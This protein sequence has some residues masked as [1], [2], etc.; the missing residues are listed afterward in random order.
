MDVVW[1]HD[2]HNQL[3]KPK[4]K[5]SSTLT[6]TPMLECGTRIK[7]VELAAI[8]QIW[9]LTPIGTDKSLTTT[10]QHKHGTHSSEN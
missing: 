6:L 1:A 9:H 8:G 2:S 3:W 10:G 4:L 7:C 5:Q